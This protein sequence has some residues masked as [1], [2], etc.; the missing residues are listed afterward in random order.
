MQFFYQIRKIFLK[1]PKVFSH[2]LVVSFCLCVESQFVPDILK[3]Q[4][5]IS[6]K[7]INTFR[8]NQTDV[9]SH[10]MSAYDELRFFTGGPLST[11]KIIS[12]YILIRKQLNVPE[13]IMRRIHAI[14]NNNKR[15][16]RGSGAIDHPL[17]PRAAIDNAEFIAKLAGETSPNT[18][19]GM[20]HV[21]FVRLAH[22]SL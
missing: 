2:R 4:T 14:Y 11:M 19:D 10:P 13:N 15:Q 6:S 5:L 16:V 8:V 12:G 1:D 20:H 22:L 18:S 21:W 9:G 7:S 3:E 17:M